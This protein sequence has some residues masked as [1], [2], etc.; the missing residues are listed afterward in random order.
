MV[1]EGSL[2]SF[3]VANKQI[4]F[5]VERVQFEHSALDGHEDALQELELDLLANHFPIFIDNN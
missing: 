1:R 4:S 3:G 2:P 5:L